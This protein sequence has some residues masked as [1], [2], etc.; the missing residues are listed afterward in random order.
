MRKEEDDREG[1]IGWEEY[2]P[3]R[4][5]GEERQEVQVPGD[6]GGKGGRWYGKRRRGK[7]EAQGVSE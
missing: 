7:E 3:K 6:G 1:N 5:R 2:V 4:V